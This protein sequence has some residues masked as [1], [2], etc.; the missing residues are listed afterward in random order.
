MGEATASSSHSVSTRSRRRCARKQSMRTGRRSTEPAAGS[1]GAPSSR[2]AGCRAGT[3]QPEG[4]LVYRGRVRIG[5]LAQRAQH[6]GRVALPSRGERPPRPGEL[7]LGPPG[8]ARHPAQL[9][10]RLG[11]TPAPGGGACRR[12]GL[13]GLAG[14]AAPLGLGG[15]RRLARPRPQHRTRP[16]GSGLAC[17]FVAAAHRLSGAEIWIPLRVGLVC[18]GSGGSASC[19]GRT[20]CGLVRRYGGRGHRARAARARVPRVWPCGVAGPR[21]ARGRPRGRGPR[22]PAVPR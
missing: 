22:A 12:A 14:F 11:G 8:V 2:P 17:H 20:S 1:R 5:V 4:A 3:D 7:E 15:R 10:G 13:R 18:P 19:V 9:V 21:G 6:P 16:A